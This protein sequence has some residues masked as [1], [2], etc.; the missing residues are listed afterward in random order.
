MLRS[1]I[2]N[3]DEQLCAHLRTGEDVLW[4]GRAT[5][6]HTTQRAGSKPGLLKRIFGSRCAENQEIAPSISHLYILTSKRI[7]D[8]VNGT[9]QREWMLMLGMVQNIETREDG[10]GDI[11]F[12]YE[13]PAG[14]TKRIPCG[15][16]NVPNVAD[17]QKKLAAA[18]DAAYMAS[19]WT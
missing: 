4:C 15:L 11:I 9:L 8:V 17:V 2:N 13:L 1:M 18:I 10:T 6:C 3:D 16:L 12:D 5:P 19:P 14:Q 7:L